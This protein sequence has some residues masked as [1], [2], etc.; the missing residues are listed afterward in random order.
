[1]ET[2]DVAIPYVDPTPENEDSN[3]NNNTN[4][5]IRFI[6]IERRSNK[7]TALGIFISIILIIMYFTFLL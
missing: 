4:P 5:I 3:P 6:D 7:Q 2:N 1:M